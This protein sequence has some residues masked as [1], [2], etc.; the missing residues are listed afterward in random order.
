MVERVE[1]A[2]EKMLPASKIR[3]IMKSCGDPNNPISA[4]SVIVVSKAAVSK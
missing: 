2:E 4:E 3:T 1:K